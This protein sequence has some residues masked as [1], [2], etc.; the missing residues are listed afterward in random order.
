MWPAWIFLFLSGGYVLKWREATGG[1]VRVKG[2]GRRE[3]GVGDVS[4]YWARKDELQLRIIRLGYL[5]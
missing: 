4:Q 3:G 2:Q 1:G 5:R